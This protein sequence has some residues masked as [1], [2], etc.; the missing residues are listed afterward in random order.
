MKAL[1]LFFLLSFGGLLSACAGA[2][3]PVTTWDNID[4]SWKT[5][6]NNV[7]T[8]GEGRALLF[9]GAKDGAEKV[10]IR[11]EVTPVKP[12]AGVGRA[13]LGVGK[14]REN[15]WYMAFDVG[16]D[17]VRKIIL[18]N[19][20]EGEMIDPA[21]DELFEPM[22]GMRG[23][24]NET[25]WNWG[26]KYLVNFRLDRQLVAVQVK[27]SAGRTVWFRGYKFKIE[28]RKPFGRPFL[29]DEGGCRVKFA[30]V[31]ADQS[32]L[33]KE[34]VIRTVGDTSFMAYESI[35][36]AP[37]ITDKATGFFRVVRQGDGRSWVIDPLG[38]GLILL[39]ISGVAYWGCGSQRTGVSHYKEWN[40]AHYES[41]EAWRKETEARLHKWGFNHLAGDAAEFR[42]SKF[43][44]S[45]HLRIG[46]ELALMADDPDRWITPNEHSPC[47][48][49]P[50][51]FHPKF[52]DYC[53]DVAESRCAPSR[54]DPWLLGYFIDNELA[55]WGRGE[56]DTGIFDEVMKKPDGHSAKQALKA[57]LASQGASLG[58]PTTEVKLGF[59]K[60][61][62]E[63]YFSV[64]TAAIRKADPNHLVLGC[65]FAGF[66]GGHR[67]VWKIAGKY[68][69]VM[70]VNIYPWAD[71]DRGIITY[72]GKPITEYFAEYYQLS[73]K[74]F[75]ITEWSFPA[76]DTPCPCMFGAGQRHRTQETRAQASDLFLKTLLA[77]PSVIGSDFF[78]WVD[79]PPEGVS[80]DF[81][82]DTNYG[83]VNEKGEPYQKL[84]D[85]FAEINANALK[86][87]K[88][89]P[90]G[91]RVTSGKKKD[92]RKSEKPDEKPDGVKLKAFLK[93]LPTLAPGK[94]VAVHQREK[95]AYKVTNSAGLALEGSI[96]GKD[97]F[98]SV[99]LGETEVGSLGFSVFAKLDSGELVDVEAT[100]VKR[101]GWRVSK[102]IG[103][104][105]LTV[106]GR[107]NGVAFE[108][109]ASILVPDGKPWMVVE[110][111]DVSNTG[112]KPFY[113]LAAGINPHADYKADRALRREVPSVWKF[114]KN[115]AW[116]AM[117]E[118]YFG[119]VS[120]A[121]GCRE[122]DL[123]YNRHTKREWEHS[124]FA[125]RARLNAGA[126][127][128][129][130]GESWAIVA[131]GEKGS[132]VLSWTKF[133][134][135]IADL[136]L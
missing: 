3:V 110:I 21:E 32:G 12:G 17:G 96:G 1:A 92:K 62:A 34:H 122:I 94:G 80:D 38:K 87:R 33:V 18:R 25:V 36:N 126:T 129:T 101:A 2:L 27:D 100:Q 136:K 127:V 67:E 70:T 11:A 77:T 66:G 114:P 81:P 82:E 63:K 68:C 50:N 102:G 5:T 52:A 83:I 135:L 22:P 111:L 35:A 71:L 124:R 128:E 73:G 49:F 13:G 43:M 103:D 134:S 4:G 8:I 108:L 53:R 123:H 107:G 120:R 15:G 75:F 55:W 57:Y 97:A 42:Y 7:A 31:Q 91:L 23:G 106:A 44:H 117:D 112:D 78:R 64:T 85:V 98:R 84:A 74:P 51:P 45:M 58:E 76:L 41:R 131:A 46:E 105:R 9:G 19:A 28:P 115:A 89:P 90:P 133:V 6:G 30:D 121:E 14:D 132:G 79:E 65:R 93:H 56:R 88:A 40:D 61:A 29:L 48:A 109:S 119:I 16:E 47:T 60:L 37:Q 69:D 59:L 125:P 24:T 54:D 95:D 10:R 104:L 113:L 118:R 26:E 116:I 86:W 72:A 130:D 20:V 99:R 39:G